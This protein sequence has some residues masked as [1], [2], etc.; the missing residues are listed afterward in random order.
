MCCGVLQCAGVC[1]SV[2]C[3]VAVC[4]TV[5]QQH[6][7]QCVALS[8]YVLHCVA[9]TRIAACYGDACCSWLACASS[10]SEY[11]TMT[12]PLVSEICVQILYWAWNTAF[13]SLTV[14]IV[15]NTCTLRYTRHSRLP[16]LPSLQSSFPP[17]SCYQCARI[18]HQILEPPFPSP[19]SPFPLHPNPL[20]PR[21]CALAPQLM[22]YGFYFK[23]KSTVI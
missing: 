3:C 18:G 19:Q 4:I 2:L 11:H 14:I 12:L 5:L 7:L 9:A 23:E 21:S 15:T 6:I 17:P 8:S 16:P 13:H 22:T 1:C 10:T 20:N